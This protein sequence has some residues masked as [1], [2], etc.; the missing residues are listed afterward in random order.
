MAVNDTFKA[1]GDAVAKAHMSYDAEKREIVV[2]GK[3][4]LETAITT[5]N[6]KEGTT[7]S[8]KDVQAAF[9]FATAYAGGTGH[10]T[11]EM[12]IGAMAKDKEVDVLSA[13]FPVAKQVNVTHQV[14]RSAVTRNV[15]T[16]EETTHYG[17]LKTELPIR[18]I[19]AGS[20][21]EWKNLRDSLKEQGEIKLNKG[22]K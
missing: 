13:T 16:G 12:A 20:N 9:S 11:G 14:H 4:A 17:V 6:E 10:A 5:Y 8:K 7:L 2:D 18:S 1:I 15:Q 21:S 22:K 19:K 3:A